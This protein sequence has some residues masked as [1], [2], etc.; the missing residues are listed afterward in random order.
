VE[1]ESAPLGSDSFPFD[2]A[3]S[4]PRKDSLVSATL[5]FPFQ[6]LQCVNALFAKAAITSWEG[7]TKMHIRKLI[8]RWTLLA[9]AICGLPANGEQPPNIV[10]IFTDDQGYADVGSYGAKGFETPN[11]DRLA[12]EGMRFTDWYVAQAV[13]SA[14]RA[15][16]LT[17]CYPN[18]IGIMGALGPRSRHGIH[19]DETTLA[20]VCKSKGYATAI[21]GKW[22]LGFQKEFLPLQHG[23]D[24]YYGLQRHVAIA[25]QLRA[26]TGSGCPSKT[27]LS[28]VADV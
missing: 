9:A 28:R 23:F 7:E 4:I 19:S 12:A 18:R 25:S 22:H 21:F 3:C 24:E 17:G 10:I 16:L 8:I 14:S 6:S 27:R 26:P 5:G 20:E 15:A 1:N 2:H 13:C 11:I